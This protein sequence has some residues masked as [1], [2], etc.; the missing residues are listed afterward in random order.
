MRV[1]RFLQPQPQAPKKNTVG[2]IKPNT[3]GNRNVVVMSFGIFLTR[4]FFIILFFFN[5]E[6][7]LRLIRNRN[8]R[9]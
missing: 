9:W 7:L 2:K 6:F 8:K 4:A 3:F 5:M 1:V